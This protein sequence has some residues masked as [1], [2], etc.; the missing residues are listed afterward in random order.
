MTRKIDDGF[1]MRVKSMHLFRDEKLCDSP[2][3]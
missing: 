2:E 3:L 1:L